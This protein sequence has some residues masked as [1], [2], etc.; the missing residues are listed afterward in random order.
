MSIFREDLEVSFANLAQDLAKRGK[1]RYLEQFRNSPVMQQIVDAISFET[2][3]AYDE[4]LSV[5]K[6]RTLG[7]GE[8]GYAEGVQLD[9]IGYLVG[10]ARIVANSKPVDYFTPFMQEHDEGQEQFAADVAKAWSKNGR[11]FEEA[12]LQDG[13]YRKLIFAKIF[14]NQER[15]CSLPDV[16]LAGSYIYGHL[17]TL[18]KI[19]AQHYLLGFLS[20]SSEEG[21]P[22]VDADSLQAI[23]LVRVAWNNTQVDNF[24]ALPIPPSVLLDTNDIIIFPKEQTE[25]PEQEIPNAFIPDTQQGLVGLADLTPDYPKLAIKINI[26]GIL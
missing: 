14:K 12:Q 26:G 15:G 7:T 9:K 22:S 18:V 21:Q 8:E 23:Y 5:L 19:G 4:I 20:T 6:G 16:R 17:L 1:S 10:Q 3:T 2:Q 24:Y 11:L 13:M 25:D